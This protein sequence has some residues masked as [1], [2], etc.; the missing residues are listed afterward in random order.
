MKSLK[1]K[2]T[3]ILAIVMLGLLVYAYKTMFAP[4]DDVSSADNT[5]ATQR[6]E[7]IMNQINGINFDTS[8]MQ[9]P[10]FKS[11][12]SIETPLISLPV[13]RSNPFAPVSGSK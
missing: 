8:V 3:A 9:E 12:K 13:G 4:A 5:I 1:N 11:L 7:M 6:V 10:S 2:R